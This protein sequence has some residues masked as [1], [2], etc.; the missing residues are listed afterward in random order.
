VA[1]GCLAI[2][3]PLVQTPEPQKKKKK[4]KSKLRDMRVHHSGKNGNKDKSEH[5]KRPSGEKAW[6][7]R[8]AA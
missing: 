1:E 8:E 6:T 3:R 5:R 7:S 4:K 2:S